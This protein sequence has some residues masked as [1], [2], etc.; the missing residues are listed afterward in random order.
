[1]RVFV[2]VLPYF[3][4]SNST[5]WKYNFNLA[6][7]P[8]FAT[9]LSMCYPRFSAHSIIENYK[10]VARRAKSKACFTVAPQ[11]VFRDLDSRQLRASG[12]NVIFCHSLFPRNHGGLPVVWQYSVL[13]P[14]MQV[15]WGYTQAGIDAEIDFKRPA[16]AEAALVQVSTLSEA[17]RLAQTYPSL[18]NKF[19]DIPFFLPNIESIS[20]E[21]VRSKFSDKRTVITFVGRDA[22][23]KGLP[24][25]LDALE[26]IGSANNAA[27]EVNV[28]SNFSD[29][30]V[31]LPKWRNLRHFKSMAH[32]DALN[33]IRSS[34]I[35]AM[36]SRFE[37]Y[38]FVFI[39]AMAAGA[40]VLVPNW[41]V[42]REIADFG[43]AGIVSDV[44]APSV[45]KALQSALESRT[46]LMQLAL[47]GL[48]RYRTHYACD[49]V[50]RRYAY[51][52]AEAWKRSATLTRPMAG[53]GSIPLEA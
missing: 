36:P 3:V 15:A 1:M 23:R 25:L 50:A 29:G 19:I 49:V 42:Q 8:E 52:F 18:E 14:V 46:R 17:K 38:G 24:A 37:G 20:N 33:L 40:V 7:I 44:D 6:R 26:S 9:N 43:N 48:N 28:V 16:F 34:H 13:D 4:G 30:L 12:C 11:P 31:P 2:D 5:D 53:S 32:R 27:I 47:S 41:E 45:G 39:E 35:V 22:R 21:V 51:A 10:Y